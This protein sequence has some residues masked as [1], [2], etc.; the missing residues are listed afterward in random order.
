M[1]D[2]QPTPPMARPRIAAG[3]LFFDGH[4][5]VLLVQPSYKQNL[6]LPG[7]YVEPG[8]APLAGCMRE[9]HEELG[10]KPTIG[11]LLVVDWAPNPGEGDKILF[12][13]DGGVLR[14]EDQA[15]IRLCA[16]EITSYAFYDPAEL[17]RVVMPRLARRILLAIEAHRM[18]QTWYAEHGTVST[19]LVPP[20]A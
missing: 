20:E 4:D 17:D 10:I 16:E 12:V 18:R 13:F 14:P 1:T 6:D 9:V 2:G 11:S 8:E 19:C 5:R 3:A 15:Q 7:G